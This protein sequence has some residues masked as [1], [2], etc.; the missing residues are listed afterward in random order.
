MDNLIRTGLVV[1]MLGISAPAL[2]AEPVELSD[3]ALDAVAAGALR[4]STSAGEI[5]RGGLTSLTGTDLGSGRIVAFTKRLSSTGL[6][7]GRIIS[8][9]NSLTGMDLGSG[10]FSSFFQGLTG[11]DLGSGR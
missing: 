11:T 8:R 1:V 10:R 4:S 3:S 6:G 7:S 5:F 9:A 2:A